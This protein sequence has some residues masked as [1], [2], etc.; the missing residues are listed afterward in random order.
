MFVRAFNEDGRDFICASTKRMKE[1][2]DSEMEVVLPVKYKPGPGGKKRK[3]PPPKEVIPVPQMI[4]HFVMNLPATAIEFLGRAPAIVLTLDAFRG[5]YQGS[6]EMFHPHTTTLLPMIHV[7][8]FQNP[9]VA[10]ENIL[11]EVREALGH[12]ID[13]QALT[14]HNVR[15]VA[16]NKVCDA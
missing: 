14:I 16:P 6:R 10:P 5:V 2:H 1:W 13:E 11:K 15:K 7:Y 3:S 4:S 8:C 12:D 9:T